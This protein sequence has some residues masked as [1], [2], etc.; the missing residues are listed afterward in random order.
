MCSGINLEIL[1]PRNYK[2]TSIMHNMDIPIFKMNTTAKIVVRVLINSNTSV[3]M[4]GESPIF[5]YV[6]IAR[7]CKFIGR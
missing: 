4:N 7:Y 1:P 2:F 3:I 5:T 6:S